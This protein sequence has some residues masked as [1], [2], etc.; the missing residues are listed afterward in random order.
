MI[1]QSAYIDFLK[2][3]LEGNL[4]LP[5][6]AKE[7]DWRLMMLWA[8]KQAIVGIIY[9]GIL[10]VGRSLDIPFNILM[11]WIGY[12]QQI[13]IRNRQI[14]KKIG[15]VCNQ[16]IR[17][18]FRNCILKGQGVALYYPNPLLRTPG[19]IDIWLEGGRDKV[20]EYVTEKYGN[21][22]ERYHHVELEMENDIEVEI[23]F[24][25]SYMHSPFS[26]KR[27]QEWF[28]NQKEEQFRNLVELEDCETKV[29]VPT[30]EFNTVY[31]LEHIYR[32]LF[33]EGIG[34]R[35]VIDYYYLLRSSTK[36]EIRKEKLEMTLK[37][38][39]LWKFSGALMWVLHE[40]FGLK[41]DYLIAEPNARE[42]KFLW[43]EIM[44]GGNFGQYDMRLRAH[45]NEGFLRRNVRMAVRNMRFV[46]HYPEEALSE[47]VF[48]IGHYLWRKKNGL[49]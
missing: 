22:L 8:K 45:Q 42:G 31:L 37:S 11:E 1:V 9:G 40:Q 34:L 33:S 41:K 7:I 44:I 4:P 24:T 43:N 49:K 46:K 20:M 5:K 3:S 14:N 29:A 18:G 39:G 23:H 21:L 12:T 28:H 16:Y 19:D 2:Y 47:P 27:L 38:L 17:D 13:E 15:E 30:K 35:Q 48:R 10:N 26:N 36:L 25:P 32:H 6:S